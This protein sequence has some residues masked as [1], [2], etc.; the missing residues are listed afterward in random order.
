MQ[1]DLWLI[2]EL[3]L[4]ALDRTPDLQPSESG[5]LR[6][7]RNGRAS[8]T[9]PAFRAGCVDR[10]R[11]RQDAQYWQAVLACHRLDAPQEALVLPAHDQDTGVEPSFGEQPEELHA[12]D[13]WHLEIGDDDV[14]RPRVS[15][16]ISKAVGRRCRLRARRARQGPPA[17]VPS[18]RRTNSSSSTTSTDSAATCRDPLPLG[19]RPLIDST[20]CATWTASRSTSCSRLARA[21]T[22]ETRSPARAPDSICAKRAA[23]AGAATV[24]GRA[25]QPMREAGRCRADSPSL[26]IAARRRAS[27]VCLLDKRREPSPRPN[28]SSP[29][30]IVAKA[31]PVDR[32][33]VGRPAGSGL[34]HR[35]SALP[36]RLQGDGF[37][38]GVVHAG[39]QAEIT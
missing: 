34:T 3:E 10:D 37:D 31:V 22:I 24:R 18:R 35:S 4:A 36:E 12:V 2:H 8:E 9:R 33:L 38:E 32:R 6:P 16:A 7:A 25:L 13:A 28:C 15:A 39:G 20:S 27:P 11:L 19:S 23:R 5:R 14:Q 26:D 17:C 29:P 1:V 30:V 21:L